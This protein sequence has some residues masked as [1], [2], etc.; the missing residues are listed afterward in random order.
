MSSR[1][2]RRT[3]CNKTIDGKLCEPIE[4]MIADVPE[5]SVGSVIDKIGPAQGRSGLHDARSAA[6]CGWNSWFPTRGL[7]GYRNEFLDRHPRRGHH[8]LHA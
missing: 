7:F 2:P 3:C 6:A 1:S 5:A 8:G 4:R